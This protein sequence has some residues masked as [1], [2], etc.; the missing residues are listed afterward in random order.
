MGMVPSI[1]DVHLMYEQHISHTTCTRGYVIGLYYC[2]RALHTKTPN[3]E[4]LY[5][6]ESR[7]V[8]FSLFCQFLS[9]PVTNPLV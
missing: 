3:P 1:I 4:I 6:A 9:R 7:M 2:C 8:T 5:S